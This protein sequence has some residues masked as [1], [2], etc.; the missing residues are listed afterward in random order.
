VSASA[1]YLYSWFLLMY[2]RSHRYFFAPRDPRLCMWRCNVIRNQ[3]C[4]VKIVIK[5]AT[6]E[7]YLYFVCL[8]YF[9]KIYFHIEYFVFNEQK[10]N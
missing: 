10:V 4:S 6:F 3:F 7:S 8:I 2:V 5:G 9:S 1:V